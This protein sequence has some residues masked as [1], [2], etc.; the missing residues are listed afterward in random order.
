MAW[1]FL[2]MMTDG[3]RAPMI[4]MLFVYYYVVLVLREY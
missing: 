1:R 3:H 4:R 2:T